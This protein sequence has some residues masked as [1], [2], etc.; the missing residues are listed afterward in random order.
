MAKAAAKKDAGKAK[1]RA[2]KV[3]RTAIGFHD[4]YVAAPSRKAALAAWGTDKDLFARGAAEVV[5]DPALTAEALA[6]PG[7]V[8]RRTRG[9][10]AE[11]LKAAGSAPVATRASKV[12]GP[13]DAPPTRK[14]AKAPAPPPKPRVPKP[15]PSRDKLDAAEAARDAA[16]AKAEA[17]RA[18]LR[19]EEETLRQRRETFERAQRKA[20]EKLNEATEQARRAYEEAMERWRAEEE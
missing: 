5:D 13:E 18:A 4:A 12:T 6:A 1:G 19:A 8:I 7:T 9:S 16:T 17:D 11:Q 10:L 2:L 3:F 14:R 20:L 15:R